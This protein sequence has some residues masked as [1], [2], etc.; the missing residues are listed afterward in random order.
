MKLVALM[1]AL[2]PLAAFAAPNRH[3]VCKFSDIQERGAYFIDLTP[4][5]TRLLGLRYEGTESETYDVS[6][7]V[8]FRYENE[9]DAESFFAWYN[10][11]NGGYSFQLEFAGSGKL[12][13]KF[14]T[15]IVD[16]DGQKDAAVVD[17]WHLACERIL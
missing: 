2:F 10:E 3:F 17:T 6:K 14:N 7:M 11:G 8:Q 12:P 9:R 5:G 16:K 1:L 4:D 15:V 13:G